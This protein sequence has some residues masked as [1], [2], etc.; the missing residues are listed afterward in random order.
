MKIEDFMGGGDT[1][2]MQAD[3]DFDAL[4]G[5]FKECDARRLEQ[6]RR[7]LWRRLG[8]SEDQA[9]KLLDLLQEV[10]ENSDSIWDGDEFHDESDDD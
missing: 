7:I 8:L 6:L 4:Y 10:L 1:T 3:E 2:E 5:L 9:M